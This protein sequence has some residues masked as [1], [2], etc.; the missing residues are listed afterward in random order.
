MILTSL[1]EMLPVKEGKQALLGID[2]GD[3]T[4]GLALSDT[5]WKIAS[6]YKTILRTKFKADARALQEVILKENV[7]GIIIGFP[8]NMNATEGPRVQK[9][10]QFTQNLT[11]MIAIPMAY[12]DERLSTIG[13]SHVL[14]EAGLSSRKQKKVVDKLAA[15]FILQG[16][17]DYFDQNKLDY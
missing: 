1:Q 2:L 4:L 10:R 13:A 17:L 9:T 5:R 12:W 16:A 11:Q 14:R 15:S 6:P 8:L 3:K 7:G